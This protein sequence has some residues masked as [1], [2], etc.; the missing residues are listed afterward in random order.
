MDKREQ[1][2]E[3]TELQVKREMKTLYT[4]FYNAVFNLA[5]FIPLSN[6]VIPSPTVH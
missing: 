4:C 1:I 2:I 3:Y 5:C 6:T